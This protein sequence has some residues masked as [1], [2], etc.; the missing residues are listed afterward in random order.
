MPVTVMVVIP[1]GCTSTLKLVANVPL[2]LVIAAT[3]DAVIP[4]STLTAS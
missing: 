1:A 3:M 2:L 4:K